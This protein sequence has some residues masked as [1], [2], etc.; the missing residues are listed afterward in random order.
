M[1]LH[2][3]LRCVQALECPP[4]TCSESRDAPAVTLRYPCFAND[5]P[6]L[7]SVRSSPGDSLMPRNGLRKDLQHLRAQGSGTSLRPHQPDD[8]DRI[9]L[10]TTDKPEAIT[11]IGHRW[12]LRHAKL[13][14]RTPRRGVEL[15]ACE[16]RPSAFDLHKQ[17]PP[18]SRGPCTQMSG[19]V[20][21]L[22]YR[23]AENIASIR[24][25]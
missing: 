15:L 13:I 19:T 18:R 24:A 9:H 4:R 20:N 7:L 16:Q 17:K 12:T 5:R 23:Y 14:Q 10:Q 22:W 3:W 8:S 11:E 2:S 21:Y 1:S 6:R 25:S